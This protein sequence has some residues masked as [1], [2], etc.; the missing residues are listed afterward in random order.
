MVQPTSEMSDAMLT[1][2]RARP[3]LAFDHVP[4]GAGTANQKARRSSKARS[5]S[6]PERRRPL[7]APRGERARASVSGTPVDA[8][9]DGRTVAELKKVNWLERQ[10]R[11]QAQELRLA[12]GLPET[13]EPLDDFSC[14]LQRAIL[15]HGR[16]FVSREHVCF[17]SNVFGVRTLLALPF[18]EVA[19]ISKVSTL[20][21]KCVVSSK[22]ASN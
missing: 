20:V 12:F 2:R 18:R 3:S 19:S 9:S 13:E 4:G 14:A 17:S 5:S 21:S 7:S 10:R 8:G 15:M 1:A 11:Q 22:Q 16:L 6:P